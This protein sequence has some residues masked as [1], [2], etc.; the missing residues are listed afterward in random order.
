MTTLADKVILLGAD[1]RP[2]M[3]EQDMYDACK[4]R[5][6]LYMMNIQ[7]GRMIL[8]SIENG[9]LL[10][11]TVEENG[12]TN[13][14]LQGLPPE[15]YALVSNHKV[16]KELWERI[17]LLMQGTSLTK[18]E[19]ECKLYDE[20]DKFAYKKGESLSDFYL[21]FSLL[22]ND[23]NI[24]NMK[25]ENFQVNTKF[26][27][28]LPPKWRK[29]VTDIKLV[30]DLH[31]T[32]VDHLHAYL[33]QHEYHAN[34][35]SQY[36]SHAQSS[37]PL[38]ITYPSNDFQSSVHHNL[39]NSS[40]SIPQME[41]AP[42]VHQQSEFS[43]PDTGLVVPV[44]QK[45]DD[46]IDAINHMMSFLTAVVTSR[47]PPTNN[48]L[49]NSS[50]PRQQATINN[51][52]VTVQLI[53]GRQNS[54]ADG[55]GHMLKQCIKPKRKR[56]E[57]WFKDKVLLVQAQ[58]N[59]Q[60]L[61]EEELVFLADPGIAEAQSTQYV[62]TNNAAYQADD[63]DAYDFDCDEI[64]SAKIGLMV[65]LSHYGSDNLAEV[66]NLDNVTNNVI[67]Q[68]VQA[69]LIFEQLNIMNHS[70]NEI[71]SDSN[72]IPYSQYMNKSQYITIQNSDFPAQEDALI[73]S[74]IEQL[75][76][77]VVNCKINQDNKSVNKIL[78]AELERY[79]DQTE[80]S[81][82]QVFWSQNSDNSD[83]PNLSTRPTLVEVP[84]ELPKVSMVNSS[85][86]KLKFHLAIFDVV[87]KERT[88]ATAITGFKQ[89][90]AC[91]RDEIIPF[92]KELKDLF[93]SFD[94]FLIDE[95]TK[96][97][98]VFNPMKQA[99]E[100]HR[101]E[102]N[103]FQD[104]MKEVLN[105][106]ERLLEQAISIDIV[107]LVVSA[108][109][110]N[111]Y[112]SMNE[113]ERCVI[114]ETELQKDFIKKECYGN[115]CPLTRVTTTAIVPL[116][117]PIPLESNKSKPVDSG[118]SKYMTGNRSQLTNFVN[119][120]LGTVKF[121]NDHVANIMGYGNY[122]IWNVTISK[123]YFMEGL[124]H[125][126]F[127]VGQF[128][129]SDLEVAFR[130][131][132][133][134]IRNLEGV[135]LLTGSRGKN[136]Y[137]LSLGDMMA[138]SPICLL[139]K[140]SKTKPWLWHRRLSH[141]N[142]G[143]INHLARQ[144]LVRGLPKLKFEKDHHCSACAM[145]KS[146][147]K[148]HKPKSEDTNQEKLYLLHMDLCRPMHVKR[149]NGKKYILVIVDD[150]SRFT[151]VK[152]LRSKDEALDFIIKFLKMIQVRLTMPVRHIQTDNGTEF[153]NQTLREYYEQVGIYHEISVAR[154]PQQNDVVKRRN[155]T[156]IKAACTMLIYAQAL[157]FL[158]AEAVATACYTQ[159]R[160]I[161][162]LFQP[163][164]DELLTPPPTV[165]P[166]APEVI[167]PIADVIPPEQAESTGS[168]SSTTVGQDASSLSKSQTTPETLS[169][170][171]PHDVEEDNHD[172]EVA[173]MG[174]D[175]LFDM[176]IL[177]VASD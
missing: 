102:T 47:Y 128:C 71:T 86:K 20:F 39:Y 172:I 160:S 49:R 43:Q 148:S 84:K 111:A 97:Q 89:A 22:L 93:N 83:E 170:V 66:H 122:K 175:P 73:L 105:E 145:G 162:L 34:E 149:V 5:M 166:P 113:C 163:L 136:L 139:S 142:F 2:P 53:Q 90:K 132:T 141:L 25:L 95:L 121:G 143:A 27:N 118:C 4:R 38:S 16:A 31:M 70:D 165:D 150:Y 138:S 173:H 98:N 177:D 79:K 82:E 168:P 60:V 147:K 29:F 62:I 129:D 72:I 32:N 137:T 76:T 176:P 46:P 169:H 100:Q 69:M 144:G 92:V 64:N 114:L 115:V 30:K 108:N 1:N 153:V 28:T 61:H 131:H 17:Q 171:I 112:E 124:G 55:Q 119:K 77:Q 104:K 56:G 54:L 75:K 133:C 127:F 152:C 130:Q 101:V 117:K 48:L 125:N 58:A 81:A 99:V 107:N 67:N 14:I 23:M 135:D 167:A 151:W 126:L 161:D 37:T 74:V 140:A 3:L 24:Y 158:C 19:R 68:A 42:P 164:F 52:R 146:K 35:S 94:Q 106:N 87:V 12:A 18:Q 8:E 155:R 96:V 78:I 21:I 59:G 65:N 44:F 7:H 26:L 103:R 110:N 154:S 80:L 51:G 57:A 13:I 15:V 9:P 159:N 156:L 41:Y 88:T 10:W 120:F 123:V 45:G 85:L 50:N 109:V 63:L 6:K 157:L 36:G 11:P 134:F 40:S 91:F 116:K 33:G 174:N